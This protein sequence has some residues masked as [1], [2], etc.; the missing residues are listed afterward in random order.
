VNRAERRGFSLIEVL[1]AIAIITILIGLLLVALVGARGRARATAC[2]SNSRQLVTTI[3]ALA[4]GNG[5]R[6]PENRVKVGAEQHITW[7][8]GLS[9]SGAFPEG[10][11]WACPDHPDTGPQSEIGV[12]DE[13]GTTCVDD[14]A[15]SYALNGHVLWRRSVE[16]KEA[17]RADTAIQRPS[18]TV[19]VVETRAMFPDMRVTNFLVAQDDGV[20]GAYGF[21]HQ[22]KG[23]Y[24]FLDGHAE[25]I[26]FLETGSPDCRWHNGQDLSDDTITP[27]PPEETKPHA[28]PDWEYLVPKVYLK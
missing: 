19:L 24:A 26:R 16:A 28:H 17:I 6:L 3:A 8:A 10:A 13:A 18:H 14:V 4:A 27:L 12:R 7:R 5:G 25:Q 9:K 15:S 2:L 1:V 11:A 20:G 22:R 21:W 23:T